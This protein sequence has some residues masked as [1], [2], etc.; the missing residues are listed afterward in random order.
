MGFE[1]L[2]PINDFDFDEKFED[3]KSI[4]N[5]ELFKKAIDEHNELKEVIWIGIYHCVN[6][7]ECE[8][9]CLTVL[10][11]NFELIVDSD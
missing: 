3:I 7:F 1:K 8:N 6:T 5:I 10:N 9:E 4:D 2:N 11:R